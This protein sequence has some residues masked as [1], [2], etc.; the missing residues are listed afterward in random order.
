M[1]MAEECSELHFILTEKALVKLPKNTLY[2]QVVDVK[3]NKALKS[4]CIF[5]INP[6]RCLNIGRYF[7]EVFLFLFSWIQRPCDSGGVTDT[8]LPKAL[9]LQTVCAAKMDKC[10]CVASRNRIWV[11]WGITGGEVQTQNANDI[12]FGF[13]TLFSPSGKKSLKKRSVWR[14][15][16][17]SLSNKCKEI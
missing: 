16:Q 9:S 17:Y 11:T 4:S 1:Q 7:Y 14:N 5:V 8:K 6:I 2:L 15:N 3:T 12:S 13:D 10:D